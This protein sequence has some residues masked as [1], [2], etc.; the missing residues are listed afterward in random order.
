MSKGAFR[1]VERYVTDNDS[2]GKFPGR[3]HRRNSPRI[4]GQRAIF[5]A[6]ASTLGFGVT[7]KPSVPVVVGWV[8]LCVGCK[9]TKDWLGFY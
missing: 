4:S 8:D 3:D 9:E 7:L 6:E 5:S 1:G 2:T